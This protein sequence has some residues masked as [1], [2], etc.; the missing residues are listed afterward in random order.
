MKYKVRWKKT[1]MRGVERLKKGHL[2]CYKLKEEE[3][4]VI[5]RAFHVERIAYAQPL[6]QGGL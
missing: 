5:G 3:S 2:N 6:Q 4:P 1:A